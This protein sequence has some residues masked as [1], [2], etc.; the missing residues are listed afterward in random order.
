MKKYIVERCF[1]RRLSF[2]IHLGEAGKKLLRLTRRLE[3]HSSFQQGMHLPQIDKGLQEL[4][5]RQP[6]IISSRQHQR[7]KTPSTNSFE[8]NSEFKT[9]N[10]YEI[11]SYHPSILYISLATWCIVCKEEYYMYLPLTKSLVKAPPLEGKKT[12]HS[13]E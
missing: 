9:R 1:S 4:K 2:N 11:H 5:P 8:V 13:E 3:N 6:C 12:K 7:I 10:V